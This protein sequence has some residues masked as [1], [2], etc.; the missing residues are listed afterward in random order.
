MNKLDKDEGLAMLK[1][2]VTIAH[3]IEADPMDF[4]KGK[5]WTVSLK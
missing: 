1:C 3:P 5:M 2:L 4:F